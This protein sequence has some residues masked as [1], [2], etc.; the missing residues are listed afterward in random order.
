MIDSV[1][2]SQRSSGL[3]VRYRIIGKGEKLL[4]L[5][6]TWVD[7]FI[8]DE[9]F[10]GL[11]E[12]FELLIPDI[13][14][15]GQSRSSNTFSLDQYAELFE[16]LLE[17][18]DWRD[19][20]VV[21]HSF[22]GGIALHMGAKCSRVSR[23]V[24]FNPIG[25][26]FQRPEIMK[27]YPEMIFKAVS[28]LAHDKKS[29]ILKKL[30]LDAGHVLIK[31]PLKPI[32]ETITQCLCEDEQVLKQIHVP[33]NIIWAKQ[34]ELLPLSYIKRLHVL[35]PTISVHYIEG[36]H[37]WCLVDQQYTLRLLLKVLS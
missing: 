14:P 17:T 8:F 16:E 2:E 29:H 18:L 26:P 36:H 4:F 15:F 13:P 10:N 32:V 19:V 35:V 30:L 7:P 33:V 9:L 11:S 34:D 3:T 24:G 25:V 12:K 27:Q 28:K 23:I 5:H 20:V 6:G 1:F 21:G 37:N 31:N 22:G